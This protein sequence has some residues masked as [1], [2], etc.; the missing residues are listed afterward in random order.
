MGEKF[1]VKPENI[2]A[3]F[4]SSIGQVV[5]YFHSDNPCTMTTYGIGSYGIR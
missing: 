5:I 1:F 3:Y 2:E 4:D